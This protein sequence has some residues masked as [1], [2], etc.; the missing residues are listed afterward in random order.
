MLKNFILHLFKSII[1]LIMKYHYKK[2]N[3]NKCLEIIC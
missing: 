1:E 2:F 3:S